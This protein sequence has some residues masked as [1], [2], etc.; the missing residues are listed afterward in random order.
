M[1]DEVGGLDEQFGLG[2]FEDDDFCIRLRAAGYGIY[3]CAD[4]RQ[5]TVGALERPFWEALCEGVGRPDLLGTQF[6][7]DARGTWR[8]LWRER[9]SDEWLEALAKI[10]DGEKP[11]P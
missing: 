5:I 8:E 11:T 9:S 7:P 1:I 10:R 2:N 6:D 4:G 3:D